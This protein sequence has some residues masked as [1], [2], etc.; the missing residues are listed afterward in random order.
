MK[1]ISFH[2]T[3]VSQQGVAKMLETRPDIQV[4]AEQKRLPK[5]RQRAAMRKRLQQGPSM[6]DPNAGF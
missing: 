4:K 2:R 1:A 6:P 5:E 3:E